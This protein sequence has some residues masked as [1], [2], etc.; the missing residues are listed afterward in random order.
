MP[1]MTGYEFAEKLFDQYKDKSLFNAS[2][3]RHCP[4]LVACTSE[5]SPAAIKKC[6]EYGFEKII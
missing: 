5:S 1:V 3:I 6:K 4:Y 2:E